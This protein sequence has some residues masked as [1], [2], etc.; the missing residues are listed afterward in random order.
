MLKFVEKIFDPLTLMIIGSN[1]GIT[2]Y[3]F[4]EKNASIQ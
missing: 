1:E 3:E 4:N 2:F